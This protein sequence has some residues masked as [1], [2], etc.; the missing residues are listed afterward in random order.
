MARCGVRRAVLVSGLV[1][2]AGPYRVYCGVVRVRGAGPA[3]VGS[4]GS[5][6][7]RLG[8]TL[9]IL[10]GIPLAARTPAHVS[11]VRTGDMARVYQWYAGRTLRRGWL[12]PVRWLGGSVGW[13]NS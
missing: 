7:I 11:A 12:C 8:H 3:P 10:R 5:M 2:C 1:R 13:Y 4:A 9:G 6:G